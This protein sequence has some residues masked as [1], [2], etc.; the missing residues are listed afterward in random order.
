MKSGQPESYLPRSAPQTASRLR[1]L[2]GHGHGV[3][4]AIAGF[5]A[6][7]AIPLLI[8]GRK[9][10][11]QVA[12]FPPLILILMLAA[13]VLAWQLNA[14]RLRLLLAGRAGELGQMR[15][16]LIVVATEFA[17][18][19]TPGGAGAPLTLLTL[20]AR[21]GLRPAH[22]SG[23]FVVDQ[24]MDS[25][26]FL[27]ALLVVFAYL[28]VAALNVEL[29]WMVAAPALF[30]VALLIML[31][32]IMRH[33]MGLLRLGARV[34]CRFH[35]RRATRFGLAR[36]LLHVRHALIQTLRLPKWILLIALLLASVNWLLRY[37]LL[38]LA[39]I[40][41]GHSI[42]WGWSFLIQVVST[43]A[44][45]VSLI[46]GGAGST[47]LASS[48]LLLPILGAQS[49]ATVILVWRFATFYFVLLAGA[50]VFAA[51]TG[52]S[53]ADLLRMRRERRSDF[54]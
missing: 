17:A 53:V 45:H 24:L 54:K 28:I 1:R 41:V 44:G 49:T 29:V 42:E 19:L 50:P 52:R 38:Y 36:R 18:R 9:A 10:L 23:I 46:P 27:T 21:S 20:L 11:I 16:F 39:I 40:G 37:S 5:T 14:L 34:L 2:F 31:W 13:L 51:L 43:G 7:L 48:A 32:Q 30:L 12:A 22:T 6:A 3:W 8:G 15:A 47:E 35:V 4:I 33:Y 26:F 25:L